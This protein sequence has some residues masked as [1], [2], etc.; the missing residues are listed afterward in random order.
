MLDRSGW[1]HSRT[2]PTNTKRGPAGDNWRYTLGT[3]PDDPVIFGV[4]PDPKPENALCRFN[5]NGAMMHA[6]AR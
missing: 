5:T 1:K 3:L 4:G 6:D 2:K